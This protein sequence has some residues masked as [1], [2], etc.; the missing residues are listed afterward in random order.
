MSSVF[1]WKLQRRSYFWWRRAFHRPSLVLFLFLLWGV[2]FIGIW[3][4]FSA[5]ELREESRPLNLL[6]VPLTSV[7][8]GAHK[9]VLGSP[10]GKNVTARLSLR[11]LTCPPY[12]AVALDRLQIPLEHLPRKRVTS[13]AAKYNRRAHGC[14]KDGIWHRVRAED[15]REIIRGIVRLSGIAKGSF[16]L[17]WGSGC[18]QSMQFMYEE[19]GVK[20][21]GIDVANATVFYARLLTS[22]ELLHCVADGTNLS[23]VPTDFFDH[24]ISFGSVL[25]VFN[26][27]LFCNVLRQ[28]VRVVRPLGTVYNGWSDE[29]DFRRRHVPLCLADLPVTYKIV[30]EKDAFSHVRVFPL[31]ARQSKPNTY[32]LV[33][34]KHSRERTALVPDK[35]YSEIELMPFRCHGPK[36]MTCGA[37][38]ESEAGQTLAREVL[39]NDS[40]PVEWPPCPPYDPS[41][42]L[43]RIPL[44][45]LPRKKST[46]VAQKYDRRAHGCHKDGIW[47]RVS[48]KDH[49]AILRVI[50]GLLNV[51]KDDRLLDWGS[52]CGHH[53]QFM[54]D[55]YS[56]VGM[57]ID[58]SNKTTEYAQAMTTKR[59]RYCV[60]DGT[61]MEWL[62]SNFF[63]HAFSFGSIYHVY[64]ETL[65]CSVLQQMTR[66]VKS[67]GK[68]YNGWTDE[69]EFPSQ[70]VKLCLTEVIPP[71]C[72]QVE[73]LEE[74]KLFKHVKL[75]PL[76]ARR[77]VPNTY[78]LLIHKL[79]SCQST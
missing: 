11:G 49:E 19:Y 32:S 5:A 33:I 45:H 73:I 68:V 20:S 22:D 7:S 57:G 15:H 56:A 21:I 74:V 63:D 52:G 69:S 3:R 37:L 78:S 6:S 35:V 46:S 14:L 65:F 60:A 61:R 54:H 8:T 48:L 27:T 64:N 43:R 51:K 67:G 77:R 72:V 41:F 79:P 53:L 1:Q 34:T 44:E 47:H 71:N 23:W 9:V 59:N 24:V 25:H 17:D 2:L 66:V 38:S 40:K 31:K 18:G 26:Q 13:V 10:G 42:E 4:L 36:G 39:S 30:E 75:F 12:D 28:M 55:F 16:V 58:L 62:P 29:S 50:A 76:K 70:K